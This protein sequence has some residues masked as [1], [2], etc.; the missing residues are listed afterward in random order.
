VYVEDRTATSDGN[1][2]VMEPKTLFFRTTTGQD[3]KLR[4]EELNPTVGQALM[5]ENEWGQT[6]RVELVA[7][8]GQTVHWGA[9]CGGHE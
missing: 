7:V 6:G 9:C 4:E 2:I 8:D 1:E 3:G 5:V